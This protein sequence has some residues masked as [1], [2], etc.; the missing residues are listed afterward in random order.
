[1]T[2]SWKTLLLA[3][4]A[5]GVEAD[6]TQSSL[7]QLV[8]IAAARWISS[9][10]MDFR[11]TENQTA[12]GGV[13]PPVREIRLDDL[14]PTFDNTGNS[15]CCPP[16]TINDGTACVFPESSVCPQGSRLE[17]NM[18]VSSPICPDGLFWDNSHCSDLNGPQCPKDTTPEGAH[19]VSEFD[20]KCAD[21]FDYKC[22]KCVANHDPTCPKGFDIHE[23]GLC[24]SQVPPRCLGKDL[25]A[26][27]GF[28]IDTDGPRCPQYSRP[29]R[30]GRCLGDKGPECDPDYDFVDGVC[31]HT[32]RVVCE[33]DG[34]ING[35]DCETKVPPTCEVGEP[36]EGETCVKDAVC[37]TDHGYVLA[38]NMCTKSNPG[39]LELSKDPG[40]G[41][42]M[43][44][45]QGTS[46]NGVGCR[47]EKDGDEP[48]PAGSKATGN[49]CQYEPRPVEC[50]SPMELRGDKCEARASPECSEGDPH[51]GKCVLKQPPTCP[52]CFRL[53]GDK[54]I[55]TTKPICPGKSK[56][57]NGMCI[58]NDP[59]CPPKFR[60]EQNECIADE[61]PTCKDG[62]YYSEG[63]CKHSSV[64]VCEKP[65][66]LHNG[67][68]VSPT[69]PHCEREERYDNG[70]CVSTKPPTC[71]SNGNFRLLNGKCVRTDGGP[72]CPGILQ[73]VAGKCV[74][75]GV[76]KCPDRHI[77]VGDNCVSD[78][79]PRCE[80]TLTFD[81]ATGKCISRDGPTC[82]ED[83]EID[84]GQCKSKKEKPQCESDHTMDSEGNC[85]AKVPPGC[86]EGSH[87][88]DGHC[89]LDSGPKCPEKTTPVGNKCIAEQPPGC[90]SPLVLSGTACV[91]TDPPRCGQNMAFDR[92]TSKCIVATKREC[93]S[94]EVCPAIGAP[95]LS[96]A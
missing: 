31:R 51:K 6:D 27:K 96:A 38:N 68:C 36:A 81:H 19:C 94:M 55:K 85:V 69:N 64:P 86:P 41:T 33:G 89:I 12:V 58:G 39:D 67:K 16:G 70:D 90:T 10:S 77:R 23:D 21:G 92:A 91:S 26:E 46:Y 9:S 7:G 60:L 35:N 72:S 5:L 14:I 66:Y 59:I 88:M 65:T 54:C 75:L 1:M 61:D 71:N 22:G 48:C 80:G 11:F 17:G 95:S 42:Y 43:C 13:L 63:L 62:F 93:F 73:L 84:N 29:T 8:Q 20:P 25:K 4:L 79:D 18:C 30:D 83:T 40:S 47:S 49:E 32:I 45:P 15:R 3:S 2:L 44:C 78:K 28:C 53:V 34:I 82:P 74:Q 52:S 76:A 50:P 24:Y 57:F 56:L 37:D 87:L